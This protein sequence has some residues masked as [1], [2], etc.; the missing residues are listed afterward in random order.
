MAIG[1]KT[2]TIALNTT[3]QAFKV[4]TQC[5]QV[6]VYENDQAGTQDYTYSRPFST[7]TAVTRPSGSKTRFLPQGGKKYFYPGETFAWLATA[8][9]SITMVQAEDEGA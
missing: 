6:V 3:P 1:D 9:G 4:N 7:S 5:G 8:A 2:Q